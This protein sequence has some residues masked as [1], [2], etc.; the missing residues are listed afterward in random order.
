MSDL[1]PMAQR[2]TGGGGNLICT[3]EISPKNEIKKSKISKMK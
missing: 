2:P 3:S 1:G